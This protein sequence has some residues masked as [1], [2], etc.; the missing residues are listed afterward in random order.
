MFNHFILAHVLDGRTPKLSTTTTSKPVRTAPRT[1][2]IWVKASSSPGLVC[3]FT[4]WALLYD[5]HDLDYN[6]PS[7]QQVQDD[8]LGACSMWTES[9]RPFISTLVLT[10]LSIHAVLSIIV[11]FPTPSVVKAHGKSGREQQFGTLLLLGKF[12]PKT[13]NSWVS[14]AS[15]LSSS[16]V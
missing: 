12:T 10:L 6:A 7:Q 14:W 5:N 9:I 11:I 1:R 4:P 15:L 13:E 2:V 16:L 8:Q 3:L